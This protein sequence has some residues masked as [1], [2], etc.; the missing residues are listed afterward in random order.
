VQ[1][2]PTQF[3]GT[4]P[5]YLKGRP[6]YSRELAEVLRSELHLDGRGRLVDVGCG[7]GTVGVQLASLFGHVSFVD[8]DPDMLAEARSHAAS[9]DLVDVDF[10]QS[11][12]ENLLTLRLGPA[13]VATF[14]QSFH[15]T[16][17]LRVAEAVYELLEPG[18][19][20]VLIAHNPD[21]PPPRQP[22]D[23]ALIPHR[24]IR[25]L[26]HR[27]LGPELRSG[28]R[29]AAAYGTERDEHTL[30]RTRFD[31]PRVVFA[32]GRPDLIYDPDQVIANY[33]SMSF[34]SP[35]LLSERLSD[36]V[37]DLRTLLRGS[38][39]SGRFWEWPG[40]T[41]MVIATRH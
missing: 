37:R 10:H 26:I 29:S 24:E 27:Y 14:G 9:A 38:A 28:A 21:R 22:P 4:A 25:Q 41:E 17:R 36:F 1:Y 20:I 32:P 11:T 3:R 40:D 18:G 35:H 16:D 6:P 2:D 33:L 39:Q 5:F 19:A 31:S 12:A 13:R 8:P 23:T 30:A 15:R 34:A 7:P